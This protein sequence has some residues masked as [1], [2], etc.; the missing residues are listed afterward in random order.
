MLQ[1]FCVT[2]AAIAGVTRKRWSRSL[3]FKLTH[4]PDPLD[5]FLPDAKT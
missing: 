2:P 3:D 4:Y 1:S 5:D